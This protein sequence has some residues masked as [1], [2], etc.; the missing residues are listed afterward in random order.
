MLPPAAEIFSDAEDEKLWTVTFT[1]TEMSPFPR[2]L[3]G[4]PLRAAP[5]L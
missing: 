5:A 4:W 1:L 2:T 3:T